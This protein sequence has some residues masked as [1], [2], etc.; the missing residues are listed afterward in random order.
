MKTVLIALLCVVAQATHAAIIELDLYS[1]GD[2]LITRDTESGLEW[3]DIS[4]PTGLSLSELA[5]NEL[6]ST[7][8]FRIATFGELEDLYIR[9][10]SVSS[11]GVITSNTT[12]AVNLLATHG[13]SEIGPTPMIEEFGHPLTSQS[14][15]FI[16]SMIFYQNILTSTI[17]PTAAYNSEF[18]SSPQSYSLV[19]VREAS[20]VPIPASAWLLGSG[21]LILARLSRRRLS[22]ST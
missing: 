4:V 1:P 13:W 12:P 20:V 5:S 16:A 7:Y 21:L 15:D 19:L 8:G 2:S 18:S 11:N 3:L 6:S 10:G 17:W 22:P 14:P 9:A